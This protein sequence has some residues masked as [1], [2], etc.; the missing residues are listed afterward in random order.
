MIITKKEFGKIARET[1]FEH[2][3]GTID[4]MEMPPVLET[5]TLMKITTMIVDGRKSLYKENE[6]EKDLNKTDVIEAFATAASKEENQR[7]T[8]DRHPGLFLML[9]LEQ[10]IIASEIVSKLFKK[11]ED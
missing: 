11:E 8:A 3:M 4:R 1:A 10:G 9:T 7:P 2:I 5:Y 6:T